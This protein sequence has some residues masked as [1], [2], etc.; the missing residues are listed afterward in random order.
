MARRLRA[1]ARALHE[2]VSRSADPCPLPRATSPRGGG[3]RGRRSPAGRAPLPRRA[4]V[5]WRARA[6]LPRTG[7][8]LAC[9]R[10]A[11]LP[12]VGAARA[13]RSAPVHRAGP[14]G[15]RQRRSCPQRGGWTEFP[16][17]GSRTGSAPTRR[18]GPTPTTARP[19]RSPFP[20]RRE[21]TTGHPSFFPR[22]W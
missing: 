11:A 17:A 21:H 14:H 4:S 9:P 12:R 18:S 19:W 5:P 16:V 15:R 3:E 20:T 10:S 22:G 8:A 7:E 13:V 6:A 2:E 1:D